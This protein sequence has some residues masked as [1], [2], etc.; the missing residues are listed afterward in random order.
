MTTMATE[1][2]II[3]RE[4]F[5]GDKPLARADD[6]PIC[7]TACWSAF[8]FGANLLSKVKNFAPWIVTPRKWDAS[9]KR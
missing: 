3:C 5:H 2:C 7:T 1:R 8:M 6:G 4:V 9:V